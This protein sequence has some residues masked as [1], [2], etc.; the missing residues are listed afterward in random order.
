[1]DISLVNKSMSEESNNQIEPPSN[2]D[3]GKLSIEFTRSHSKMEELVP[4]AHE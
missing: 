4:S 2:L 1:M 3:C